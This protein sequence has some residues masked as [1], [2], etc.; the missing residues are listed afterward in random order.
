MSEQVKVVVSKVW[1]Q[2]DAKGTEWVYIS[3]RNT[4]DNSGYQT[5]TFAQYKG[6]ATKTAEALDALNAG[7]YVLLNLKQNG[8][9]LNLQSVVVLT[10]T[11]PADTSGGSASGGGSSAPA[12]SGGGYQKKGSM[13]KAE[14]AAKDA[15]KEASIARS[16]AL[17]EAVNLG[18]AQQ[19][20]DP[21]EIIV[22]ARHLADF[23]INDAGRVVD[24]EPVVQTGNNQV[25][26]PGV[27]EDDDIPF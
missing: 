2:D 19:M 11:P 9:F 26:D 5:R 1:H 21:D 10:E 27:T 4:A 8:K 3:G 22:L 13:S 18:I 7:D 20:Y 17:K 6:K 16:V 23:L 25:D 24:G 12:T 15:K 14:W